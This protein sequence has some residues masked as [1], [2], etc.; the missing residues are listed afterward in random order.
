MLLGIFQLRHPIGFNDNE[1]AMVI[2]MNTYI[3][4]LTHKY[5]WSI[6]YKDI[7]TFI[8]DILS[9]FDLVGWYIF[10]VHGFW[11]YFC[12]CSFYKSINC[13]EIMQNL[14]KL[15]SDMPQTII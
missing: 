10:V 12:Q 5:D 13:V 15:N 14:T 3:D 4:I 7:F 6:I 1:I 8:F 11:V 9:I 2:Y